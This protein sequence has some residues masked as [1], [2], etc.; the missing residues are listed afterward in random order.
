MVMKM[1]D[2]EAAP[3]SITTSPQKAHQKAILAYK[4]KSY[5]KAFKIWHYLASKND[6][7]A[8]YNVGV[9]YEKGLGIM[10]D[11][12]QALSWYKVAAKQ[13]HKD[14]QYNIGHLYEHGNGIK[15]DY[16]TAIKWYRSACN[17]DDQQAMMKLNQL[18][19]K[20]ESRINRDEDGFAAYQ[21][22]D[23]RR[24]AETWFLEAENKNIKAQYNIGLLYLS[25]EGVVRDEWEGL[26]WI[27]AAADNGLMEAQVTLAELY[28]QGG[29]VIEQNFNVAAIWFEQ[30]ATQNVAEAQFQLGVYYEYGIGVKRNDTVALQWYEKAAK[31]NHEEAKQALLP[32]RSTVKHEVIAEQH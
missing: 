27:T 22:G 10:E 3:K 5:I 13:N 21:I 20:I 29:E 14:A 6:L 15:Q 7:A 8:Q 11:L 25:G 19:T 12:F 18:K 16:V 26:Q 28:A 23:Y 2:S 4:S 32:K 9:M 31:Q 24:A 30:A 17:N 1:N